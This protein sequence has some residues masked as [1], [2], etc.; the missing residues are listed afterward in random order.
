MAFKDKLNKIGKWFVEYEDEEVENDTI[1]SNCT[2]VT[3]PTPEVKKE[4]T[5][6]YEPNPKYDEDF[7]RSK[8]F[9]EPVKTKEEP[10]KETNLVEE[11]MTD[12][13]P[14]EEKPRIRD[15]FGDDEVEEVK[16]TPKPKLYNEYKY[17]REE[18][19]LKPTSYGLYKEEKKIFQPTPIISP[20]YGVL[21][22]NYQKE[23]IRDKNKKGKPV[24]YSQF[25]KIDVDDIRKKAYGTLEDE[26]NDSM[27]EVRNDAIIFNN[28]IDSRLEDD[29]EISDYEEQPIDIF[30]E[31]AKKDALDDLLDN[32]NIKDDDKLDE[33][34]EEYEEP[35]EEEIEDTYE[36]SYEDNDG[37][38]D[39]DLFGLIDSMYN[40]E[41][42]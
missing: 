20:V 33:I 40:K 26:L 42:E 24:I 17:T 32:Y 6:E 9:E 23:D 25:D 12:I 3:I 30:K 19:V 36:D 7:D 41:E 1:N 15:F 11:Y 38:E 21:D 2:H 18:T 10:K 8:L 29:I 22:K 37:L 34:D 13:M 39:D 16:E 4:E 27:E 28:D 31:L 14:K 5:H 35:T